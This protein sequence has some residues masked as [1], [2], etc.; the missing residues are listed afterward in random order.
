MFEKTAHFCSLKNFYC[1]NIQR[2]LLRSTR[3]TALKVAHN[4]RVT[5][6]CLTRIKLA[7]KSQGRLGNQH[8]NIDTIE[9]R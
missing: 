8:M 3:A 7:D 2:D 1:F 5:T 9:H 6:G 4:D